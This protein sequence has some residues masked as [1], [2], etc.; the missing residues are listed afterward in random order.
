MTHITYKD[1]NNKEYINRM[2]ISIDRIDSNLGYTK[3]NIQLVGAI[4]NQIKTDMSNDEFINMC[5][6]ITN[7]NKK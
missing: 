4:I 7:Y 3:D 1:D 5:S 2:N 6:I